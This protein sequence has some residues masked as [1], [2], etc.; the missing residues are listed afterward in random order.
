M[1]VTP[2]KV[3]YPSQWRRKSA[4]ECSGE[5]LLCTTRGDS[6]RVAQVMLLRG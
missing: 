5:G 3:L 6:L 1:C 4:V 2:K